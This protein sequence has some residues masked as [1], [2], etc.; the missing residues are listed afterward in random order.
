MSILFTRSDKVFLFQHRNKSILYLRLNKSILYQELNM[1][2]LL[3]EL[4]KSIPVHVFGGCGNNSCSRRNGDCFTD[5]ERSYKFYLAFENSLCR[6]YITEKFW[7]R[8]GEIYE[9]TEKTLFKH[10]LTNL[11]FKI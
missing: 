6:E 3:Q 11:C 2:I 1:C 8:I 7:H 9:V 10:P 5:L 4:K